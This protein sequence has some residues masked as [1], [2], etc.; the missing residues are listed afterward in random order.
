[1]SHVKRTFGNVHGFELMQCKQNIAPVR[2]IRTKPTA[3]TGHLYTLFAVRGF[4]VSA[5]KYL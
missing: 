4:I 2:A 1:M 3:L 5:Q